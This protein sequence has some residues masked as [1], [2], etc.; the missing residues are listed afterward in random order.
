MVL[1]NN[2]F[3]HGRTDM[4]HDNKKYAYNL[5]FYLNSYKNNL[6]QKF[7]K[8]LNQNLIDLKYYD[9]FF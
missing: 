8:L 4:A 3:Y 2:I 7:E 9:I 5:Y 6:H 1:Q